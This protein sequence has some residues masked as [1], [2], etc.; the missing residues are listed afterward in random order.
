MSD[1]VALTDDELFS[2][3]DENSELVDLMQGLFEE[4][5]I[6]SPSNTRS[7]QEVS[8]QQEI[9]K[10][11]DQARKNGEATPYENPSF[12]L[13][14]P[15]RAGTLK[16]TVKTQIQTNRRTNFYLDAPWA[17][18]MFNKKFPIYYYPPVDSSIHDQVKALTDPSR[19]WLSEMFHYLYGTSSYIEVQFWVKKAVP[20]LILKCN[21]HPT[22]LKLPGQP[23][24]EKTISHNEAKWARNALVFGVNFNCTRTCFKSEI[25]IF[26]RVRSGHLYFESDLV[27][28]PFRRSEKRK[29]DSPSGSIHIQENHDLV[30]PSK[31]QLTAKYP[32]PNNTGNATH[33]DTSSASP[34]I[35]KPNLGV[36]VPPSLILRGPDNLIPP[37]PSIAPPLPAL[38]YDEEGLKQLHKQQQILLQQIQLH[39]QNYQLQLQLQ[40]LQSQQGKLV[41]LPTN[42]PIA[43]SNAGST[44]APASSSISQSI[45]RSLNQFMNKKAP[46]AP[47]PDAAISSSLW[48]DSDV[49][50]PS[51]LDIP[52]MMSPP[53][54]GSTANLGMPSPPTKK[55]FSSSISSSFNSNELFSFDNWN[56]FIPEMP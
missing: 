13:L 16:L 22:I 14:E 11:A 39:H 30:H 7:D 51:S 42:A 8:Q 41:G 1:D 55:R 52:E 9:K 32:T 12:V 35:S 31:R 49:T 38:L 26:V 24:N 15:K 36:A 21:A 19:V 18:D 2:A 53:F 25:Y 28:L 33:E 29:G 6:I 45:T 23:F 34:S 46:P 48:T 20:Q 37:T 10:T 50:S 40:Q 5:G 54:Y 4:P 3:A 27:E 56:D 43:D 47:L 44:P 17:S